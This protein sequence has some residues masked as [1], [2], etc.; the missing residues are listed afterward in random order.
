[1][2][3]DKLY[4]IHIS[5]CIQH[6][7]NYTQGN[8]EAFVKSKMKQDAV[9]RNFEIMGE[10]AKRVSDSLKSLTPTFHGD[11]LLDL[12]ISSSTTIWE[13]IPMKYGKLLKSICPNSNVL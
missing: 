3:D 7:E 13:W 9:I 10:A 4:I 1:V 8:R 12:G 6:I 2:K 5:E 11:V